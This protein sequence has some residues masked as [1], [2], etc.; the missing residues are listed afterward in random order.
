MGKTFKT[1]E[2]LPDWVPFRVGEVVDYLGLPA[3]ILEIDVREHGKPDYFIEVD[4][5]RGEV[6]QSYSE[7]V[8]LDKVPNKV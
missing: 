6:M 1:N 4:Y 8:F 2:G 5:G 7:Q 3:K